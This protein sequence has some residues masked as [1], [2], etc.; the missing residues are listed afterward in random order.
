M[1]LADDGDIGSAGPR[2]DGDDGDAE[3]GRERHVVDLDAGLLGRRD[4]G[5]RLLTGGRTFAKDDRTRAD[6]S[7]DLVEAGFD[8]VTIHDPSDNLD[9]WN[10]P[11]TRVP[12]KQLVFHAA[13]G[14]EGA[15]TT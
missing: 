11:Y 9:R 14:G 2:G 12:T 13:G 4:L 10:L 7:S 15:P 3:P 5:L 6:L 8:S 1:D